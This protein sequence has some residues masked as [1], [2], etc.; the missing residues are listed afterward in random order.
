MGNH[1]KEFL[2]VRP[3]KVKNLNKCLIFEVPI[4]NKRGYGVS[5]SRSPSQRQGEF[6]IFF[7][8]L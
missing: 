3:V 6:D 5:L 4:K 8:K 2:A 7:D 1:C